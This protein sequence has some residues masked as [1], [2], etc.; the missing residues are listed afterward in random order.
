[1]HHSPPYHIGIANP[2]PTTPA[3]SDEL[4]WI[5]DLLEKEDA[6][7]Q[8]TFLDSS[9]LGKRGALDKP[10]P[11][12]P[13][14]GAGR[15]HPFFPSLPL[16]ELGNACAKDSLEDMKPTNPFLST[17]FTYLPGAMSPGSSDVSGQCFAQ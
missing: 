5:I 7:S 3:A 13:C 6:T 2:S 8:E 12:G 17:D 11:Q 14:A 1:M 4:N 15:A 9:H 10:F 16:P